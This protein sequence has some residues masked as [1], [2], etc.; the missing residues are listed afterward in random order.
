[1]RHRAS[2]LRWR[3]GL[4]M[5]ALALALSAQ[6]FFVDASATGA[7]DG[8]SWPDAFTDLQSA[9]GVAGYLDE[10]WV[11]R[12]TYKPTATRDRLATFELDCDVYGGFDG[13]EA[14]RSDRAGLFDETILSGD[15]AGDDGPGFAGT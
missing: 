9:L 6:V 7:N 1:P 3:H 15:L 13:T 5:I 11:A 12:G 10:V 4:P 8:T 2:P 14:R